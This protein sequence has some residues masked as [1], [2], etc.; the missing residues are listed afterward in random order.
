MRIAASPVFAA[1]A[2]T[3]PARFTNGKASFSMEQHRLFNGKAWNMFFHGT[4][5]NTEICP[6][7]SEWI[8]CKGT[9][10][11]EWF[12]LSKVFQK[13]VS[14]VFQLH[15]VSNTSGTVSWP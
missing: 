5:W 2:A 1:A 10:M 11:S 4:P 7:L 3:A 13:G 15:V 14:K 8:L 9:H 6:L 12:H